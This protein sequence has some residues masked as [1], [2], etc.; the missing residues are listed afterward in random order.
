[1]KRVLVQL[2]VVGCAVAVG[3]LYATV[4]G[5][6]KVAGDP[7]ANSP[8]EPKTTSSAPGVP[9]AAGGLC[10]HN[11]DGKGCAF[12]DPT[13]IETLGF[14]G[15]HGVPE[16][17][18][19]R[20]DP[21]LIPAFV[22]RNDWCAEHMLPESQC[23]ICNP[24]IAKAGRT[25]S[26]AEAAG[27]GSAGVASSRGIEVTANADRR[28]AR[29]PS[30]DCRT[31]SLS[32]RL[33]DPALERVVDI[34]VASATVQALSE[35]LR[36]N[37]EVAYDTNRYLRLSSRVRGVVREVR[38]DLGDAVAA[39]EVVLVLDSAE[40]AAAQATFLQA[41]AL[42][43]LAETANEKIQ[44]LYKGGTSSEL[45]ALE[46][47][48]ELAEKRFALAK[49]E[50]ELRNL[51]LSD[52][53]LADI[54]SSGQTSSILELKSNI[55][56]EIVER[57]VT[58][59]EMADPS[60]TMMAIAD[61]RRSWVMLDI[62]EL[63]SGKLAIGNPV[64]LQLEALPGES[65]G[66]TVSWIS[67]QLDPATRTVKARAEIAN[68]NR[69]LRANMF[70]TA[71]IAIHEREDVLMVPKAAVQWDGCCNIVFVRES[72]SVYRP[73][74]IRLGCSVGDQYEVEEGLLA[75]EPV[76]T[77]GSFLLKTEIM[78]GSLGAGCCEVPKAKS[79]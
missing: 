54:S 33:A 31:E 46:R 67:S 76:V 59:G 34:D 63:D 43:A 13:L 25:G 2:F 51:G 64:V 11:I 57:N 58:V 1:M 30:V 69:R 24:Q 73:R 22:A 14:C 77:R 66:G 36:C 39:G 4:G 44:K 5:G 49:A 7:A 68:E 50:Q 9:A 37:A 29:P 20:C 52:G 35:K 16:A 71:Q 78:R 15:E 12:C 8:K 26:G 19:T 23:V 55:A 32:V 47:E 45:E 56:G 62:P 53:Q 38:K 41:R 6:G 28:S 75:G 21:A 48:T 17:F 10:P 3:Y 40:L 74:K 70:G 61:T 60:R 72:A 65:F 18:C 42:V 27:G 79:Q